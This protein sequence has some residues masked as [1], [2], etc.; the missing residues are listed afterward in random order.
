MSQARQTRHLCR[1]LPMKAI[2]SSC[3]LRKAWEGICQRKFPTEVRV[4]AQQRV[5]TKFQSIT[6]EK[7][8]R[9]PQ[10]GSLSLR[11]DLKGKTAK[12]SKSTQS[13][14]KVTKKPA[15]IK[16]LEKHFEK[17]EITVQCLV[18]ISRGNDPVG[19]LNHHVGKHLRK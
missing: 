3:K 5:T 11:Q 14:S 1:L 16:E 4:A 19:D 7:L 15:V 12:K 10:K 6:R 13:E 17:P 9:K 18:E 2:S 8:S